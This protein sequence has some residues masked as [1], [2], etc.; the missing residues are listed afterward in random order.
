MDCELKIYRNTSPFNFAYTYKSIIVLIKKY[1]SKKY[2]SLKKFKIEM[3]K[4][5][6][7]A[8]NEV[9]GTGDFA[10]L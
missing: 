7:H 3:A 5:V 8:Y 2:S 10:S 1:I 9:L 6:K 4:T